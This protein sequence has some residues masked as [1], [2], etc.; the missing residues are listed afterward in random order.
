MCTYL[1]CIIA[2]KMERKKFN[3][4]SG[5]IAALETFILAFDGIDILSSSLLCDISEM[6]CSDD[7][8]CVKRKCSLISV[9]QRVASQS[10]S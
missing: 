10:A 8:E 5:R 2:F 9:K 3:L 1:K 4:S 6:K 7:E